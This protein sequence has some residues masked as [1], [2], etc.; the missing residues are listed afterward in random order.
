MVLWLDGFIVNRS[1]K[2]HRALAGHLQVLNLFKA[3]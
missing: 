2:A 3:L 1:G